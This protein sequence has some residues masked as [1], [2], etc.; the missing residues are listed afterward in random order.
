[1]PGTVLALCV[2]QLSKV[3]PAHSQITLILQTGKWGSVKLKLL[4]IANW[5]ARIETWGCLTSLGVA[6]R[7]WGLGPRT[8]RALGRQLQRRCTAQPQSKTPED[9]GSWNTLQNHYRNWHDSLWAS[10][11]SHPET[12]PNPHKMGWRQDQAVT[13]NL[14]VD[15]SLGGCPHHPVTPATKP[16][17]FCNQRRCTV[18]HRNLNWLIP[19]PHPRLPPS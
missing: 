16:S 5:R 15:K 3:L 10:T 9:A 6:R 13:H 17:A 8:D 7:K 14:Q 2:H 18:G 1:M 12:P 4:L 11:S 19:H